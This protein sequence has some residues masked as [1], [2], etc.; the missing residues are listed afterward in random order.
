MFDRHRIDFSVEKLRKVK[1]KRSPNF[2]HRLS[3]CDFTKVDLVVISVM[4]SSFQ[5]VPERCQT[6]LGRC[7]P[8]GRFPSVDDGVHPLM[9]AGMMVV[10][11][12]S[13]MVIVAAGAKS[14]VQL[15]E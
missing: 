3:L 5:G 15:W 4:T 7:S 13:V 9:V 8:F 2:T 14:G 1:R 11:L 12:V 10:A 6:C